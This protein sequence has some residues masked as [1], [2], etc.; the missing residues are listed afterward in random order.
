MHGV[1]SEAIF[2]TLL[3]VLAGAI[4]VNTVYATTD[5]YSPPNQQQRDGVTI[6]AIQCN[7]SKDLYLRNFET[8]VCIS[9]TTFNIL[10]ERGLDLALYESYLRTIYML[11]ESK[12]Q[13]AQRAVEE[14]IL[15]YD[16]DKDNAFSN[17]NNISE[18]IVLHYPFVIDPETRTVVAHGFDPNRVNTP[19]LILGNYTNL[20]SDLIFDELQDGD[21]IW[22]D[23]IFLDPSTNKNGLK[24]SWIVQHDEYIFGA[25]YYYS[26]DEKIDRVFDEA[27]ALYE[28][29][30][31]EAI[32]SDYKPSSV[33]YV[34]AINPLNNTTMA[35]PQL[36]GY[37]IG[38]TAE[39]AKRLLEQSNVDNPTLAHSI[40]ATMT[41]PEIATAL[42]TNN[43]SKYLHYI[44]PAT[45]ELEPKR[46]VYR[47]H[48]GYIFATGYYY[49]VFD[50]IINVIDNTIEMYK[51]DPDGVVLTDI[52]KRDEITPHYP[53]IINAETQ[54]IAANGAFPDKIG[55]P[56][57]IFMEEFTGKTPEQ[58]ITELQAGGTWVEYTFPVPG[59]TYEE[60]KHSYLKLYDGYI[61]GSGYYTSTFTI[62]SP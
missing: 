1:Y 5:E 55:N 36:T 23:Y 16:S 20:S 24:S 2:L 54:L 38:Q 44:N 62:V 39:D 22:V 60:I 51:S 41:Y 31:F 59:S 26:I 21:G 4:S 15:M 50:K 18:N 27:I 33:D 53:F 29:G 37:V 28:S 13:N 56:S 14:T 42:Q 48:D 47:L 43:V 58:I 12:I 49:P 61:F 45:E 30:G 52:V 19:S 34:Y 7:A 32:I 46:I 10:T 35:H 17:I 57:R 9:T 25:G 3:V 40:K 8:P 11:D 6:D